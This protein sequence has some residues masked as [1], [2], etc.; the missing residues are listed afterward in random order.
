MNDGIE[1][2]NSAV[3]DIAEKPNITESVSNQLYV[4]FNHFNG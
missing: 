3:K 1:I 4:Q 2:D